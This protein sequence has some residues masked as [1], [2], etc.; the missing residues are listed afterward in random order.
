MDI[1]SSN[2]KFS[3]GYLALKMLG[4]TLYSNPFAALSE[5]IANGF[6]AGADSVYVC[7]DCRVKDKSKVIVF[8]NGNGMTDLDIR[9][10]YLKVGN[11]NRE[12]DNYVMMGR[13]GIGKLSAFYLSNHYLKLFNF[14]F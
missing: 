3:M 13:K 5:L 2:Y 4:K 6:D 9:N 11:Y 8:D 1:V 10:K 12:P 7:I 14:A